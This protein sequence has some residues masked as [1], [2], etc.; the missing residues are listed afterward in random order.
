MCLRYLNCS[1]RYERLI[2]VLGIE[3]GIGTQFS[4]IRKLEL[5]SIA[6]TYRT[7][8]TIEELY[9]FLGGGWPSIASV[10][11]A[12]LPYWN[13]MNVYHLV[14]VHSNPQRIVLHP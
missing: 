12:E 1:V 7:Y 2:K 6:V 5:L 14:V 10:Q 4:N 9:T 13:G 8:G 11:T 3:R